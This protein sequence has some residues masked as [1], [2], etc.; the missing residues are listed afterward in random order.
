MKEAARYI[1]S[2]SITELEPGQAS[3]LKW[4]KGDRHR[5][6]RF[7][8][9]SSLSFVAVMLCGVPLSSP[10]LR[11]SAICALDFRANTS[12]VLSSEPWSSTEKRFFASIWHHIQSQRGVGSYPEITIRPQSH[13]D[14]FN[15]P[16]NSLDEIPNCSTCSGRDEH[17]R[18]APVTEEEL[19]STPRALEATWHV[20][21][22]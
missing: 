20:V 8:Y 21:L 11:S 12:G 13:G 10:D 18:T 17:R 14:W 16:Q 5:S 3:G 19:A 4:K 9:R 7:W 2:F 1:K 22:E 15:I 6:G